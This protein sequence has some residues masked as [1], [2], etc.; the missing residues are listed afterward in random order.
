[1]RNL[2]S[3][4]GGLFGGAIVL[5]SDF[6]PLP[7]FVVTLGLAGV[8]YLIGQQTEDPRWLWG[9]S[10]RTI[11]G[12]IG[13]VVVSWVLFALSDVF[14]FLFWPIL[15]AAEVESS[16]GLGPETTV[17][18]FLLL[19]QVGAVYVIG[20]GALIDRATRRRTEMEVIS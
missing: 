1:M 3:V 16:L 18:V 4:V 8:Y 9:S 5:L 6:G 7:A 14:I 13:F 19:S 12:T 15:L 11:G 20:V 2:L 10:R 17:A